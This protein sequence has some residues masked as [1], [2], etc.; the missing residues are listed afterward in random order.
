MKVRTFKADRLIVVLLCAF[1]FACGSAAVDGF[2]AAAEERENLTVAGLRQPVEIIRDSWGIAHIFA[3]NEHDLF[4]AQGFNVASDR[5]FQLEIWRRQATGTVSEILGPKEILRDIGA[6]LLQYR[7]DL[8]EELNFYHPR[9]EEIVSAFGAGLNA[10][11]DLVRA[12]PNLLPLEFKLLGI[13]PGR[14]TPEVVISRHNGLFRNVGDEIALAQALQVVAP[15][16]LG[17]LI[18]LHPG[19]PDLRPPDG[20]DV[21][22]IS[23]KILEL[24]RAARSAVAFGPEDIVD[25]VA[26]AVK[27]P[28]PAPPPSLWDSSRDLAGSNNWVV[29]GRRTETGLPFLAN[30]PHRA[31]QIPSLRYWVH[32]VAPGWNVIGGGEPALPGVSIGHNEHGAWGLTI[33]SA[34]QEDLYV[35]DLDPGD[36][37]RYRYR[38]RWEK[39]TLVRED[40]PVKGEAPHRATLKFTRHGPVIYEDVEHRK[41]YALRAAWLEKGCAPYLS[42]LRMDQARN[43]REFKAAA[44][45]NRTP[46]LN[47]IWADRKG[48][49]GWQATGLAPLRKNWAGLLPVPGDGRFEWKGF[50]PARE[51]PSLYN[52]ASGFIA[53]ANQDN[54]PAG[55]PY[56]VGYVWADPF[57]FLRIMEVLGARSKVGI[58]D[59]TALQQDVLSIPAR[60]LVALVKDLGSPTADPVVRKCLDLLRRWDF[61]LAPES[62]AAA[63]Y[64]SWQRILRE[65]VERLSLPQDLKISL[66]GRS[67]SL[68]IRRLEAPDSRFGAAPAS[69]RTARDRL[70]LDALAEAAAN[71]A[72][73]FGPDPA[74][75]RY[76]DEQMHHVR[77]RHPLSEALNDGLRAT[78]DLG[79]LPRGGSGDTPNATGNG[80]NQ[81][82]GA[83]FRIVTDLA[84]WDRSLGT[85]MPGQSG[86][87]SAAHYSD[88]FKMWAEG[89]YFP[90]YFSR[91]KIE[92]A[93]EKTVL[94]VPTR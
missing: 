84:D 68:D 67:L 40:I 77:L 1:V 30:D 42:S 13:A 57:R 94:L 80:N 90:I 33:F 37:G 62:A 86:V 29:A 89:R 59:M 73:I 51:L 32:L 70:L 79:P 9:G 69:A 92:S 19:R 41:A 8:R 35:Y 6:R 54:L 47:M 12:N 36:P 65:K 64:V 75:W 3:R 91:G 50:I 82:A 88:L 52:S 83:T 71:L 24:Y 15:E 16:K 93:A 23:G 72:K 49:I 22:L 21:G 26:R 11:I 53:T 5:L 43:W 44:F 60:R 31:L 56:P 38:G 34:D 20:L 39:M 58:G 4:F 14:W 76:G 7:G 45:A 78:L 2:G 81:T 87:P 61:V 85:N 74:A 18:D 46:S 10:Y 66:P 25:A 55:F 28:A 63:G 17:E 48:D 27:G